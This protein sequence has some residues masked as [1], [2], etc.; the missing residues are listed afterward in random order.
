MSGYDVG[1]F[2]RYVDRG[3]EDECWLWTAGAK[4]PEGYGILTVRAHRLAYQLLVGAIPSG[5]TIHHQCRHPACVNP[6]H[7]E[8]VTRSENSALKRGYNRKTHCYMGHPFTPE[9][10]S[11]DYRGFQ[12]CKTCHRANQRRYLARKAAEC[13]R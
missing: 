8:V 12:R 10:T 3:D 2:W 13:Q 5:L 1:D 9:N 7:L 6:D 4:T 11:M